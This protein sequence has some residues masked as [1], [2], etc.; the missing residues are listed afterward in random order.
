MPL[1]VTSQLDSNNSPSVVSNTQVH[2]Q[3]TYQPMPGFDE[4]LRTSHDTP[5]VKSLKSD[6]NV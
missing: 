3:T 1:Q 4:F 2:G 5:Q 6:E